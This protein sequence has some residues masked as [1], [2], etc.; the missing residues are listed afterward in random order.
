MKNKKMPALV[1]A[2]ILFGLLPVIAAQK[3]GGR[4]SYGDSIVVAAGETRDSVVTFGGDITVDGTVRKNV[5]AFGGTITINGEVGDSV[6]SFGSRIT[7]KSKAVIKGDLVGFG[8]T[9]E[10]EPGYRVEKDTL[11]FKGSEGSVKIISEGLKGIFSFSFLPII[12]LF[13]LIN[14]IIWALLV[15]LVVALFPKQVTLAAGQL[16]TA[17]WPTFGVGL[18]AFFLFIFLVIIAIFL[19][20]V[21]IGIP[22]LLALMIVSFIIKTFGKVVLFYFIGES[23]AKAFHR[24]KISP[25]GGALLGLLLFSLIDL[26][27][28]LGFFV[29][30]ILSGLIWGVAV[31]TRFGTTENWFRSPAKTL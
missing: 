21:L 17:F 19:C 8:G 11:F 29:S 26:V 6:V 15:I 9:I 24:E 16:R 5:L 31:R 14:I 23:L 2:L 7:L 1:A 13:K 20:L 4:I 27:P 30:F 18:L 3:I 10:K 22:I 12:L 28:F 25:L